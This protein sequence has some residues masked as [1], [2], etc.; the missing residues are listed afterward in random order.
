M[1]RMYSTPGELGERLTT[2]T[3][4]A[5]GERLVKGNNSGGRLPMRTLNG[6]PLAKRIPRGERG[7]RGEPTKARAGGHGER[8]EHG[9]LITTI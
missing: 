8:G 5:H 1:M 7:E 4:G 9:E 3:D 2:P 6:E